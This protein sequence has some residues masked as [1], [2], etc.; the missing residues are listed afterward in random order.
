MII[1]KVDIWHLNLAFKAPVK[2]NLATHYGSDNIVVKLT[3]DAGVT[4]YGEGIPRSFVTGEVLADSLAFLK[5]VLIPEICQT[6]LVSRPSIYANLAGVGQQLG[7]ANYPAVWCAVEMAWLDAV[8]KTCGQPLAEILGFQS[9]AA[10]IYS[11]VL[12]MAAEP[13]MARFFELVKLKKMRFLKLKV[14]NKS[15]LDLLKIARQQLGWEIDIRVDANAAWSPREAMARIEAMA[16]YRLSA[17]EQPVAKEDFEGLQKVSAAVEIPII[18]D[19]SVCT[20]E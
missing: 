1:R 16:P 11:A 20:A 15:D 19:E 12:P 8:S 9:Q 3:T 18:A 4:G 10:A 7:A 6:P 17:V 13:Q 2:H 14:G 5:K